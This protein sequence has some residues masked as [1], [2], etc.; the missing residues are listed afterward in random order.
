MARYSDGEICR[1][2]I[3]EHPIE[4]KDGSLSAKVFYPDFGT[5]EETGLDRL[6]LIPADLFNSVPSQAI[7]LR[8]SGIT[9]VGGPSADWTALA[10]AKVKEIIRQGHWSVVKQVLARSSKDNF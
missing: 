8:L 1:A 7:L 5:T 9:P 3:C 2:K 4:N 6:R 10:M